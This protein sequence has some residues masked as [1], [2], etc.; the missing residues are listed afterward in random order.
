MTL[1]WSQVSLDFVEVNCG[2]KGRERDKK[3]YMIRRRLGFWA[4]GLCSD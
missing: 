4:F 3:D 1:W 2:L